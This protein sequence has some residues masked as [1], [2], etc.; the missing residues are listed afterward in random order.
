MKLP[1]EKR[2][3]K[4]AANYRAEATARHCEDCSMFREPSSCTLVE[5]RIARRGTCRFWERKKGGS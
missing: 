5:G 4:D 2:I 1:E 3:T